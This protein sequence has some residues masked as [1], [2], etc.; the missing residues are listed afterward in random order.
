MALEGRGMALL[1]THPQHVGH[2]GNRQ[3][4]KHLL[5]SLRG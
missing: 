1:N 2:F 5:G 3:P 4:V